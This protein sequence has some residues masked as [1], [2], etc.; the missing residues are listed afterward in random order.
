MYGTTCTC[1]CTSMIVY[2]LVLERNSEYCEKQN[3]GKASDKTLMGLAWDLKQ[4]GELDEEERKLKVTC[5]VIKEK[6]D[7]DLF[8]WITSNMAGQFT[9]LRKEQDTFVR[10]VSRFRRTPATHSHDQPGREKPQTLCTSCPVHSV[11][12]TRGLASPCHH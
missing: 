5:Q 2:D 10:R 8:D 4:L 12:W 9:F 7:D 1:T 6:A 11:C 3:A